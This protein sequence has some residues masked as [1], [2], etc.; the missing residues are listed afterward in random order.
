MSPFEAKYG[1]IPD[2][3]Y[4]RVFGCVAYVHIPEQLRTSTFAEKAYKGYF[5]GLKVPEFDRYRVYVPALDK[6]VESAHVLFDEYFPLVRKDEELLIVDPE[7]KT[8]DDFKYLDGLLYVDN[9]SGIQYV[10]TNVRVQMGYIVAPRAPITDR[11]RGSEEPTPF[12]AKDVELMLIE[13]LKLNV[14]KRWDNDT[15]KLFVVCSTTQGAPTRE[16][17]P[18]PDRSREQPVVASQP[19]LADPP[20]WEPP[21]GYREPSSEQPA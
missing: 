13:Y 3:S 12:H 6:V 2:V 18:R 21:V 20:V 14:M 19:G 10:T 5:T 8:V 9:E 15:N 17:R 1:L 11:S 4:F 7:R 16:S